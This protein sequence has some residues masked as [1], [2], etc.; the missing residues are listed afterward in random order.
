M[1][2]SFLFIAFFTICDIIQKEVIIMS[3]KLKKSLIATTC[4]PIANS[5]NNIIDKPT[6]N[7]GT[8]MADIWYLVFG[9]ISQAA[10]KRKLKYFYALKEYEDQLKEK[11]SKIPSDKIIEPDLQIV[12]PALDASKYCILHK[13]LINLF[14]NLISSS[15]NKDFCNFVH[16]SFSEII[17][18]MTPLDAK[19]IYIFSQKSY[20]PICNYRVY[21]R[22]ASFED[23]YRNIFLSNTCEH[24]L[25]LQSI[26][27]S[28]LKRLGLVNIDF[29]TKVKA[30][31]YKDFEYTKLYKQLQEDF[32][33]NNIPRAVDIKIVKGIVELTPY[34][35]LFVKSCVTSI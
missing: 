7:I 14:S 10:E 22:D 9:G 15:M 16:P 18:Q 12:A 5:V 24:D 21:F 31:N 1:L 20:Y 25:V 30:D 2:F 27:I 33:A 6:Q 19:N 28:S 26:S 13:E 8:T 23:Y 4:K 35:E 3:N 29:N 17:K 32:K 34:G 11:I